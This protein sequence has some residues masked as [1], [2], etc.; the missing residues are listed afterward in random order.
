MYSTFVFSPKG[1]FLCFGILFSINGFAQK[2]LD[3]NLLFF[4]LAKKN[5]D[6]PRTATLFM[7]I[8]SVI[9]YLISKTV[10]RL[11]DRANKLLNNDVGIEKQTT[12]V[13]DNLHLPH[14]VRGWE[15]HRRFVHHDIQ[16]IS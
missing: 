4:E 8:A 3:R 7:A 13:S 14:I 5:I 12:H 6:Y 10:S 16:I 9:L 2:D 1:V 11:S 15:I